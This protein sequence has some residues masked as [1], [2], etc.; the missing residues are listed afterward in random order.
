MKMQR[1]TVEPS[2]WVGR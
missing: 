2:E 1:G